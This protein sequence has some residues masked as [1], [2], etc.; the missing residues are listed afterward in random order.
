MMDTGTTG[1]I[2]IYP[3][4][5]HYL[6]YTARTTSGNTG[7]A[8]VETSFS[9]NFG[10][11]PCPADY[12]FLQDFTVALERCDEFYADLLR[13]GL[14]AILRP[15]RRAVGALAFW[16]HQVRRRRESRPRSSRNRGPLRNFN[17]AAI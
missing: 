7:T 17:R 13:P 4:G 8:T 9:S 5:L 10:A 3:V 1:S 15:G 12:G 14:A 16:N 6:V 11:D 2:Y